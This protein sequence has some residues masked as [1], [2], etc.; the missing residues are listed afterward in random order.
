MDYSDRYKWNLCTQVTQGVKYIALPT[1]RGNE[2][3]E[4]TMGTTEMAGHGASTD[5]MHMDYKATS[6]FTI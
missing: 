1:L 6:C 5:T 3:T 4:I 2:C